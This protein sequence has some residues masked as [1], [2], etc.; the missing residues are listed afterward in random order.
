MRL[1]E[2]KALRKVNINEIRHIS[3]V[4]GDCVKRY[5]HSVWMK[6]KE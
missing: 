2:T 4:E 1:I 6:K 5:L 3:P